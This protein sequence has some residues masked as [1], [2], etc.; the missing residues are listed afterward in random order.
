M[1]L[2]WNRLGYLPFCQGHQL[3]VHFLGWDTLYKVPAMRLPHKTKS[4][5]LSLWIFSTD[6]GCLTT[7]V[8]G[9][10]RVCKSYRA[11]GPNTRDQLRGTQIFH[12]L[13]RRG[14][15]R[16]IRTIRLLCTLF[17]L[18][19]RQLHCKS[20]GIRSQRLGIPAWGNRLVVA[21]RWGRGDERLGVWD[22]QRQ[23][24]TYRMERREGSKVVSR[25]PCS[26][27]S[28]RR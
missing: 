3:E 5:S 22:E 9:W 16:M 26:I 25:K 17:L 4:E 2:Y 8:F 19:L 1:D 28:D 6:S 21:K 10:S 23:T 13:G 11:M 7:Y 27:F 18:L 15:F 12:G 24:V 14:W 20:S